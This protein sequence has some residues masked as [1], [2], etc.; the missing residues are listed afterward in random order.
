MI[1]K[2][3]SSMKKT[4]E[5]DLHRILKTFRRAGD[6]A[7]Y[8]PNWKGGGVRIQLNLD[9]GLCVSITPPRFE[10]GLRPLQSPAF[11]KVLKKWSRSFLSVFIRYHYE[12]HE[13]APNLQT[14]HNFPSPRP[15]G[16]TSLQICITLIPVQPCLAHINKILL[17]P[18]GHTHNL[19]LSP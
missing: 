2:R 7:Y 6:W 17:S 3:G 1:P 8:N 4:L 14:A 12:S 18:N 10:I 15:T 5:N 9:F 13:T 11:L 16:T 19:S